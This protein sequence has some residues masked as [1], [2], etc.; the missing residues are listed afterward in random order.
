MSKINVNEDKFQILW[1]VLGTFDLL[2]YIPSY[3]SF[4]SKVNET[5]CSLDTTVIK[6]WFEQVTGE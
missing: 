5:G 6:Q 4:L 3:T 2:I 1:K